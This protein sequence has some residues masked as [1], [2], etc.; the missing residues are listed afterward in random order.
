MDLV[1]FLE[2]VGQILGYNFAEFFQPYMPPPITFFVHIFFEKYIFGAGFLFGTTCFSY[3]CIL[4]K[5]PASFST[6]F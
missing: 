5:F 4:K 3:C 6:N 1:E 2:Y